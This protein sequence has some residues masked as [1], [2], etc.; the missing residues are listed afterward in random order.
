MKYLLGVGFSTNI[1]SKNPRV[2]IYFD[3]IFIDDYFLPAFDSNKG[4]PPQ[5]VY[6]VNIPKTLKE[7]TIK[8]ILDNNDNN[9]RN[10]F[11]SKATSVMLQDFYLLPNSEDEF[12]KHILQGFSKIRQKFN[13]SKEK[14]KDNQFFNLLPYSTWTH[15]DGNHKGKSNKLYHKL[16]GTGEITCKI[17]KK[18]GIYIAKEIKKPWSF[19]FTNFAVHLDRIYKE[20]NW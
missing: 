11:L 5:N 7:F 1:F 3:D 18:Y 12:S 10:G 8:I 9:Y 4:L 19:A 13:F 6:E 2:K 16:F 15:L 17:Y 14:T 20:K